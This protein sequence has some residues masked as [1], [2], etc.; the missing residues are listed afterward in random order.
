M[1]PA[2]LLVPPRRRWHIWSPVPALRGSFA[3]LLLQSLSFPICAVQAGEI[4]GLSSSS[5]T[6]GRPVPG[7]YLPRLCEFQLCVP[8]RKPVDV[9]GMQPP[10]S[11]IGTSPSSET[12]AAS[13]NS[14]V[15]PRSLWV[16]RRGRLRGQQNQLCRRT[17][18]FPAG[19]VAGQR[20]LQ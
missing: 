10:G 16:N 4:S 5:E 3:K 12:L 17:P 15:R 20:E 1:P 19:R 11:A 18:P 7:R 9:G 8:F 14:V 6:R 2:Q 13:G